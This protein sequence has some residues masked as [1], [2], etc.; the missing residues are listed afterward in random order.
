VGGIRHEARTASLSWLARTEA[1]NHEQIYANSQILERH[2][3]FGTE[4]RSE[5]SLAPF[6]AID[7]AIIRETT[8][9][10]VSCL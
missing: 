5:I 4:K 3:L 9:S 7:Q 6:N 10:G 8:R 2:G 1:E